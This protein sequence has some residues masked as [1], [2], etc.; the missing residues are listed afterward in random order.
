MGAGGASKAVGAASLVTLGAAS[1]RATRCLFWRRDSRSLAN[2]VDATH[3]ACAFACVACAFACVFLVAS[4]GRGLLPPGRLFDDS[5]SSLVNG[6]S[7]SCFEDTAFK[8]V[9]AGSRCSWRAFHS[10]SI[11]EAPSRAHSVS[12]VQSS[13]GQ[14]THLTRYSTT[15]RRVRCCKISSTSYSSS[16]ICATLHAPAWPMCS[17]QPAVAEQ[18][19]NHCRLISPCVALETVPIEERECASSMLTMKHR[20][21][22]FGLV[23][24]V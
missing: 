6:C 11:T 22:S 23:Q 5:A 19:P 9:A 24:Y 16:S 2:P 13:N 14:L 10:P 18:T 20:A 4:A 1:P 8:L 7:R 12:H 15:P 17:T 3:G 21:F